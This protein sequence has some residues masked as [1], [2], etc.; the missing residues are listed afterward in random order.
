MDLQQALDRL[1]EKI[2]ST[3]ALSVMTGDLDSTIMTMLLM[4]KYGR[5][6]VGAVSFC[7]GD[8]EALEIKNSAD[9][10]DNVG[11]HHEVIDLSVMKNWTNT[12]AKDAPFYNMTRLS[13][14]LSL[15]EALSVEIVSIDLRGESWDSSKRFLTSVNSI[16]EQNKAAN[17]KLISPF[18]HLRLHTVI[19]LAK[20][21]DMLEH[22]RFTNMCENLDPYGRSCA[23]C[24]SCTTRIGAFMRAKV[25]DTVEYQVD[26][27]WQVEEN[28]N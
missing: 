4:K 20:E 16:V 15:A 26:I 22:L 14:A 10:C 24:P 6:K 28:A 27:P 3:T 19:E 25:A 13:M 5:T 9:F 12:D 1:P 2:L 11:I 7:N 8:P 17:I 21:L 18:R 23:R